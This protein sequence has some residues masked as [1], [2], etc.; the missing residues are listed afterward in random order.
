MYFLLPYLALAVVLAHLAVLHHPLLAEPEGL[1]VRE[2]H[3]RRR[4]GVEDRVG[5]V[6]PG[7]GGAPQGDGVAHPLLDLIRQLH[8]VVDADGRRVERHGQRLLHGGPHAEGL[9]LGGGAEERL[10]VARDR[11]VEADAARAAALLAE[12][13]RGAAFLLDVRPHV[14]GG[15]DAPDVY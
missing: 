11:H 5:A 12:D 15:D 6:V 9:A 2:Q 4:F 10:P 14:V 7:I 1:E 8:R 3:L 13:V